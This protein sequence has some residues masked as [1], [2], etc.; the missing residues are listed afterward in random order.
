MKSKSRT[1]IFLFL[2]VGFIFP[3]GKN[4]NQSSTLPANIKLK[5]NNQKEINKPLDVHD[6]RDTLNY[7][8]CTDLIYSLMFGGQDVIL[9]WFQAPADMIIREIGINCRADS[10]AT[11][12]VGLRKMNL[13][14]DS[15]Y[16]LQNEQLG[17]YI[18]QE[19]GKYSFSPFDDNQSDTINWISNK[20]TEEPFGEDLLSEYFSLEIK[21]ENNDEYQWLQMN[22][23]GYFPEIKA[24]EIIAVTI[25]NISAISDSSI[26]Y[27]KE[28]C[29]LK[30][31]GWKYYATDRISPGGLN[32]STG[33]GWW[34]K[35]GHTFDMALAVE[36]TG[37]T[38]PEIYNITKLPTTM[39]T[40]DR[41][42]S[43]TV[44]WGCSDT[45]NAVSILYKINDENIW[46]E[47][48]MVNDSSYSWKGILPGQ[49]GNTKVTYIIKAYFNDN[50]IISP[51]EIVYF[52]F[53]PTTNTLLVF[54]GLY[55]TP[56]SNLYP[57]DYYFGVS[58]FTNYTVRQFPRDVWAYGPL[59][60]ELV[61][62][63]NNIIEITTPSPNEYNDSVIVKWLDSS[64]NHNYF[65]AGQEWLGHRYDYRDSSF[66]AGSFEYDNL[67]ITHSF[68]DV[69]YAN[70]TGQYF[71]SRLYPVQGSL[72]CGDL[73]KLYNLQTPGDSLQYNP[74]Y[75]LGES[76][77]NWIDGYRVDTNSV[78]VDMYVESR[79]IGGQAHV[80]L[81]P[82]ASHLTLPAGNKIAFFSFDPL[83]INSSPDY[84]WYGFSIESP[85]NKVLDWFDITS[86]VNET[87]MLLPGEFML[88]QN[89]PNPFNPVTKIKYT[90]PHVKTGYTPSLQNVT[91]KIYDIL[92]KEI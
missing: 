82:C 54:N 90:I 36:V 61:S 34:N 20:I 92:G 17:Y 47:I 18:V 78:E 79:G 13:P 89:Y 41:E 30:N 65:L 58:D 83:A 31:F 16:K 60:D 70:T 33:I 68:N 80:E 75:E 86:D 40:E 74:N 29:S 39:S 72:L 14:V 11:V 87:K 53:V 27:I 63:Y 76:Y 8:D 52:I 69:S 59:T 77:H 28:G 67:G 37:C 35:E 43:A 26:I 38:P 46:R 88:Y 6:L 66:L 50:S 55:Y 91:L 49:P 56:N 85:Q 44:M 45:V 71:P 51:E 24:G 84:Y 32:D 9:Q 15:I 22:L 19:N 23:L 81:L 3:Q 2:I 42:V 21:K 73:Y 4:I 62:F 64:P 7:R 10:G 12:Q 25:K 5:L 57:Q 48:S 1:I